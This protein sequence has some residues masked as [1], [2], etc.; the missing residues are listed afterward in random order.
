MEILT[1][2]L[3]RTI[4]DSNLGSAT[5]P[6]R[7]LKEGREQLRCYRAMPTPGLDFDTQDQYGHVQS[8]T[9]YG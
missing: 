9:I 7:R 8:Y 4:Q 1:Y 2:V 3:V 5:A 6:K